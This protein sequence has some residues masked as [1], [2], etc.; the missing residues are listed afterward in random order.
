MT[1]FPSSSDSL[2]FKV[3]GQQC[4]RCDDEKFQTPEWYKEEVTK[5]LKNVHQ[6]IGEVRLTP[7]TGLENSC[8]LFYYV[9]TFALRLLSATTGCLF[10]RAY[11]P[12]TWFPALTTGYMFFRA[13]HCFNTCFP[14][15]STSWIF[16][17]RFLLDCVHHSENYV[18]YII[19]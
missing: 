8:R 12:V 9:F 4:Q 18:N 11:L 5:V 2:R 14:A 17:P 3:Y 16:S 15:L 7:A 6:K 13:F 10:S 19:N 1:R